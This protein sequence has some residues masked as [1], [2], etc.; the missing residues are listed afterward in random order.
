MDTI[1]DNLLTH[2]RFKLSLDFDTQ[3]NIN[4][5]IINVIKISGGTGI[6]DL[7]ISSLLIKKIKSLQETLL[8][9]DDP[10]RALRMKKRARKLEIGF[11]RVV[12]KVMKTQLKRGLIEYEG[13]F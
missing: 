12:S 11:A 3:I 1:V 13:N 8:P 9:E 6:I 10:Q 5:E 4:D 2:R 7:K